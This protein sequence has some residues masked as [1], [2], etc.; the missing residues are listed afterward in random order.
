MQGCAINTNQPVDNSL[1]LYPEPVSCLLN[2][3]EGYTVNKLTGNTIKPYL[4]ALGDT[5]KTGIPVSFSAKAIS[6]EEAVKSK[7]IEAVQFTNTI[8]KDNIHP[9]PGKLSVV[10]VDT[11]RLKIT[12]LGD[13][14]PSFVLHNSFGVLP[15]GV[16]IPVTGKKMPFSDPQPLKTSPMRFKDNAT[17]TIQ[18]LD[19]D[20]GLS[21]SYVY[22]LCE[23]R[24]GNLWFGMD[25]TGISKYDG[26]SITHYSVN[27]GLSNNTVLAIL[28]DHKSNL[29]F[30]TEGGVTCFDGKNFIQYTEK[31]GLSN[32]DVLAISEDKKGN[33][34][35]GT[36]NGLTKYNGKNFMHYTRKEGLPCDTVYECMEDRNGNIWIGT[37][38][39]LVRFDGQFFTDYTSKDG[40]SGNSVFNLLEDKNGNIWMTVAGGGINKFDGKAI[41]HFT[42]REGLS[43]NITSSIILDRNENIWVGTAGGGLNK[44]DGKIFTQY[45]LEQGLS[46][47]KIREII[48]DRNGN[49]WFGTDGGGVNKLNATSFDYPI[50]EAVM[51]N[52]RIRPILKD[53]N[54]SLWLGT[55]GGHVG[56]L[57]AERNSGGERL[58]TCY[59]VQENL[60]AKGQ[61]SLLQDKNGSI[62]IGTTGSGII[63]YDGHN[64]VNYSLSASIER[65]SIY[66]ILEDRKGNIWFG[67]RDGSIVKYDGN[68]FSFFTTE[69]GL[70][71]TIVYSMLQ[72]KIGSIWFCTEGG[73]Y[74]YD[75]ANLICYTEKEGL[76]NKSITSIAED[77]GGNIWLG[78]QGA[79]VC[80]FDGK[81][82]TYYTTQQGLSDNNVWSVFCD[83][84][85]QL[86]VGTD[87]GLNL[88]IRKKDAQQNT[89]STYAIYN[90]GYQDGLKALDFNLHSV[91]V[92]NDNRIWWG[93]GKGVASFDLN[94]GFHA[95]SVRSLRLNYVEINERFYDFRNL[96]DNA[97]D[98]I[99]LSNVNPFTNS[100]ENLSVPYDMNHLSFHFSA[101]D[102]SAPD[103]IKYSYRI[104]GL[105]E[106]WSKP[107]AEPVA[108]YRNLSHGNYQ[109][110]VKAIGQS[111]VWTLPVT[112]S[113]TIRPAWWQTVWF[114]AF[115]IIVILAMLFFLARFI[116][117][118]QLRKQKNILEKKLA[119]QYERQR[120]SAEMHD[121]IGA[122]L[123]GIRLMTEMAKSKSKDGE[124]ISEIEKIYQSVGDVSSKMKEVIWGLNVENDNIASLFSFLQKQARLMMEHYPGS[125]KIS[126]PETIPDIN[127][128]GESRRHIYLMVK[129]AL[130]NIIKHSGA[131]K[132]SVSIS[133]THKLV[134]VISDNGKGMGLNENNG[135]GNGLQ[136]IQQRIQLLGGDF[137]IKSEEGLTLTFVIPLK[138]SL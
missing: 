136:N 33:L 22:A 47:S 82:F 19:V 107:A 114:K 85:N 124:S 108:D 133:C 87:K 73:L 138:Q 27:E 66:D 63:K 67:T 123:S 1:P 32:N 102:W 61:R 80:S 24:K 81:T 94:K 109:F 45:Q 25:G 79:G 37:Y 86:W 121:D 129:E 21:F 99:E 20:Q 4:N 15:T 28:E 111:Q 10:T 122:G 68:S 77:S 128:T 55:E 69:Q 58:F 132:V 92:D 103:K 46:N 6:K 120:I 118:Y 88:F 39:G 53:K 65:Q 116:Y 23:D 97:A 49:I 41:T 100:P 12:K 101:I 9:V 54:G 74:K 112:Y 30:G 72:D 17:T 18:Y 34:W 13:G 14:D 78:T 90:F 131:D 43:S 29:W 70:P 126:L 50:P 130:H 95:D 125:F 93:T 7:N 106:T 91:C 71:G 26:V 119:V 115:L 117:H 8:I 5:F 84:A 42:T 113:F 105:E 44:F 127:I 59:K 57:A 52:N 31:E 2:V 83:S 135:G 89:N 3:N 104:V 40:L 137:T 62:W 36:K 110:Q 64:F 75:G 38:C 134:I 48:E 98:K 96:P 56:K 16:P 60:F 51:E 35:F 11:P 76:F